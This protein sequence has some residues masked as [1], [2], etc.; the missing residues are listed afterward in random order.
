[1]YITSIDVGMAGLWHAKDPAAA[2]EAA[3]LSTLAT[4]FGIAHPFAA[5]LLEE[6]WSAMEELRLLDAIAGNSKAVFAWGR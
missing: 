4:V 5:P 2:R 3:A 6:H 1:M